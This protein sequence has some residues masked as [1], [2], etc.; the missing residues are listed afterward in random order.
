MRPSKPSSRSASAAFAPASAAP[1]ITCVVGS[2]MARPS[3]KCEEL[4]AG[5]H[6]VSHETMERRGHRARAGL[7]GAAQ[8]HAGVLGLEHHADTLRRQLAL[9]PVRHLRREPLLDLEVAGEVVDHA[10]ELREPDD[11]VARDV[12]HVRDAHERQQMVLAE[13]VERDVADEHELV[14]VAVV[15][16]GGGVERLGGQE[17]GVSGGH[18]AR[19]LA[20]ALV[21]EIG[22]ERLEQVAGG[23]LDRGLVEPGERF[24]GVEGCVHAPFATAGPNFLRKKS[25][26]LRANRDRKGNLSGRSTDMSTL[27]A[28]L[29]PTPIPRPNALKRD[30]AAQAFVLMRITCTLAPILFGLA[31]LANVLTSDLTRYLATEFNDII[32]GTAGDAMHIVGVVEILAGIIVA[33]TPRFG[34]LLVAAWLGGIIVNLLLVGG[35]GD[36]AL[37][38]FGLLLGALSLWRLASA[39]ASPETSRTG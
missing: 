15:R 4:P 16:E 6:I 5:T 39:F 37:R 26:R 23:A 14:V 34:G 19:R 24:Y 1:T 35:Y 20:E 30:P 25:S 12:A 2:G 18:P 22:A 33:V 7:R 13:R 31:K 28:A 36:I 32:P 29:R 21:A 10:S 27:G 8:G 9:E 3:R 38:D 11:P 17:L